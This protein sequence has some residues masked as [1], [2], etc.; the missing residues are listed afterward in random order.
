[1]VESRWYIID[2]KYTES[3]KIFQQRVG[4]ISAIF[5]EY[6]ETAQILFNGLKS[7]FCFFN[8]AKEYFD[9]VREPIKIIREILLRAGISTRISEK[10]IYI[11]N[12]FF[13]VIPF[14]YEYENI[15]KLYRYRNRLEFEKY[16]IKYFNDNRTKRMFSKIRKRLKKS[17]KKELLRQ[18]ERAFWQ[19]DYAICI[20]S[21]VSMLDGITLTLL[22]EDSNCQHLSYKTVYALE[23]YASKC[24]FIYEFYLEVCILANLYRTLYENRTL[25]KNNKNRKLSRHLNSHGA[26][27]LNKKIEVLRLLN[28]ISFCQAI[29]EKTKNASI[30][31][32]KDTKSSSF[33]VKYKGK[34]NIGIE[35]VVND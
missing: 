25:L 5:K 17:D 14:E 26:K 33:L 27:F 11:L 29:I 23:E 22:A 6:Q 15:K 18:I 1:M 32:Y 10:D 7:T 21:L 12:K 2:Y 24:R 20:T 34:N 16:V 3:I 31:F 13:W 30:Q 4:E 35:S 8:K 9:Q 28:V 19:G